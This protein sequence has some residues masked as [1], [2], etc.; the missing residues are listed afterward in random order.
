MTRTRERRPAVNG[1]PSETSRHP[2]TDHGEFT[3]PGRLDA[4]D[5]LAEV[6]RLVAPAIVAGRRAH[7]GR[8]VGVGEPAWWD[9]ADE[10][11]L[12]GVLV[13]ALAWCL[14][15]P[16]RA[17]RQR[18]RELS[19]DLSAATDWAAASRRPS[20]TTLETIRTEPGPVA[21]PFDPVAAR[22]WVETG[23]SRDGAA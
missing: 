15:D 17:V 19:Y 5:L 9:A 4:P 21:R 10:V 11:K 6:G 14:H 2:G 18:L 3:A 20:H 1:A 16:E 23:S 8:L 13:L 12:A 22:R 7:G